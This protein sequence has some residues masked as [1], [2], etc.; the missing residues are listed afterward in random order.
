VSRATSAIL[1]LRSPSSEESLHLITMTSSESFL[2]QGDRFGLQKIYN[3]IEWS[4][5]DHS[6]QWGVNPTFNASY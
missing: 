5:G 4:P 3:D 1:S 6:E 2:Q